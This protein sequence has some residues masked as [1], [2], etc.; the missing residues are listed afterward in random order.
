MS[1]FIT[2]VARRSCERFCFSCLT[3]QH[4]GESASTGVVIAMHSYQSDPST[5]LSAHRHTSK[6][7]IPAKE[8]KRGYLTVQMLHKRGRKHTGRQKNW[9]VLKGEEVSEGKTESKK[10]KLL[11]AKGSLMFTV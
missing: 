9:V 3:D 2:K 1:L 10:K 6:P 7:G 8:R 4:A 5:C 11:M